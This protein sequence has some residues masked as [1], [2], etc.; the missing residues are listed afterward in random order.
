M[1]REIQRNI[2]IYEKRCETRQY[3]E[4]FN[5]ETY[6]KTIT[7]QIGIDEIYIKHVSGKHGTRKCNVLILKSLSKEPHNISSLEQ[8]YHKITT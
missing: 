7:T 5:A 3:E 8:G 4:D 1:L 2:Q 6:G